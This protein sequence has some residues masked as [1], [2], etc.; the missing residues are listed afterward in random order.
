MNAE[1]SRIVSGLR[2]AASKSAWSWSSSAWV[3]SL[4]SFI[5]GLRRLLGGWA[6]LVMEVVV[7]EGVHGGLTVVMSLSSQVHDPDLACDVFRVRAGRGLRRGGGGQFG[8][9]AGR[10]AV[11]PWRSECFGSGRGRP[12]PGQHKRCRCAAGLCPAPHGV[13]GAGE[14]W[15]R[16]SGAC[17]CD[18]A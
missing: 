12:V 4:I 14:P 7:D 9:E 2:C 5:C 13:V 10:G 3:N 1:R 18:V 15:G 17:S 8:S 6:G 16:A 11:R